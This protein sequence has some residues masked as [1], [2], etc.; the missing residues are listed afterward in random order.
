V[1]QPVRD[2]ADAYVQIGTLLTGFN[3]AD[4]STYHVYEDNAA[5]IERQQ[6]VVDDSLP[7]IS[8]WLDSRCR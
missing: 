7:Q 1:V 4:A 5:A 2:L 6:A 8:D 3:A